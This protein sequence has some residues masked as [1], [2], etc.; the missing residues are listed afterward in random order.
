MFGL[1]D[2]KGKKPIK[3]FIFELEKEMKEPRKQREIKAR[4]EDQIQTIKKQ[5]RGGADKSNFDQY[6]LLLH[7]YASVLKVMSRFKTTKA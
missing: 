2:Q 3:E 7:G 4:V 6:G 5:L 1:E